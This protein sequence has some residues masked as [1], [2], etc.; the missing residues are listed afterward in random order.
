MEEDEMNRSKEA[1]NG[2]QLSCPF[3]RNECLSL[4][5]GLRAQSL[6]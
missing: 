2:N 5:D 6:A 4:E 1:R 3:P